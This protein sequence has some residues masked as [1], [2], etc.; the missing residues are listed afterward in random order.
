MK[1]LFCTLLSAAAAVALL[2]G[3]TPSPQENSAGAGL[4]TKTYETAEAIS[5]LS[6]SDKYADVTVKADDVDHVVVEY[7][8]NSSYNDAF[9][10][11]GELYRFTIAGPS[12]NIQ[13]LKGDASMS[14]NN[15]KCICAMT[16]KLPRRAFAGLTVDTSN[17]NIT[18][19]DMTSP[20]NTLTTTNGNISITGGSLDNLNATANNGKVE[21]NNLLTQTFAASTRNGRISLAN[22]SALSIT[23]QAQNG[24]VKLDH[25]SSPYFY[26]T[27]TNASVVGT[28]TGRGAEY[29][30]NLTAGSGRVT[31]TD[32]N[33]DSFAIRSSAPVQQNLGAAQSFTANASNGNVNLEFVQ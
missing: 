31:L 14:V 24:D 7:S 3:F 15:S 10:T 1:K 16:V 18:I 22:T 6:V 25:T 8:Y 12:L 5:S 21:V 29:G 11:G 33:D 2:C 27:A 30:L 20:S 23:A 9:G 19:Q 28:V 13:G 4:I 26:C 32:A 17:G